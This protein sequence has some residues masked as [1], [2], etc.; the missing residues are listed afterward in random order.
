MLK[1]KLLHSASVQAAKQKNKAA[2]EILPAL[3]D[4]ESSF[5]RNVSFLD[6]TVMYAEPASQ[7]TVQLAVETG[8]AG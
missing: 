3:Q 2:L 6:L 7:A 4:V 5:S 8:H 1:P